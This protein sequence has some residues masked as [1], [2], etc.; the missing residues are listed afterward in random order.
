MQL[1]TTTN[2]KEMIDVFMEWL[3]EHKP[4]AYEDVQDKYPEW[5]EFEET[6]EYPYVE[7]EIDYM[8]EE[9]LSRIENTMV[10]E[11]RNEDEGTITWTW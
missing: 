9:C 3:E 4:D 1:V 6:R 2:K 10:F 7:G 5:E 11:T 8:I